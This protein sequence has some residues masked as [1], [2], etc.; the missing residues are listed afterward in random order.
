MRGPA[1]RESQPF[2]VEACTRVLL[3]PR[4]DMFMARHA[5]H[6]IVRGNGPHQGAERAVLDRLESSAFQTFE[7]NPN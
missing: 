3:A 2:P 5:G 1:Q 4:R 6:R 7:F